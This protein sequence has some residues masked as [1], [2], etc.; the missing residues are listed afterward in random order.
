MRALP[1]YTPA[2]ARVY[3]SSKDAKGKNKRLSALRLRRR[4]TP[5][6][7]SVAACPRRRGRR[8]G[9]R[10]GRHGVSRGR[11]PSGAS[12]VPRCAWGGPGHSGSALQPRGDVLPAGPLRRGRARVPGARARSQVGPSR[13]LQ[14]R[15]DR[16]ARGAPASGDRIL[17]TGV[18]HDHGPELA[19]SRGDGPRAAGQHAAVARDERRD[20][21]G[22]RLRQQRD[23]VAGRRD[24]RGQPPGRPI[25]RGAGRGEP[26]S[27]R[28]SRAG[29][30][31]E[32]DSGRVQTSVGAY[33]DTAYIGRD[34][35]EQVASV[36]A[37]ASWRLDAGG[38][39]RGRY[40]FAHVAGGGGFEYLDGRQ[41]RLSADAGFT[42]AS[43]LLRVGYQVELNDRRDLQ[44]GSEFFSASPTRHSLFASVAL[45]NL[46][47][48]QADARGE[49]RVSRYRD[50][51]LIDGG[52]QGILE[53]TRRDQRYG[54]AL[55]ASRPVAAPWRVFIDYSYYRNESNL[56]PYD[57]SRHQL[58]AGI[59]ASLEK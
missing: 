40:R 58:M 54:F 17:R 22:G 41:Q 52:A 57:Y 23:A 37:Q 29:L 15:L 14:P 34:R 43:A 12:I 7:R 46:A 4:F 44:Q 28:G 48:W 53:V 30:S 25:R 47:G 59:E 18:P 10:A 51:N 3:S 56:D 8:T 45:R 20:L 1:E 32:R 24:G 13:P 16:A 27:G 11:L 36:D 9:C 49:Y 19:H 33:F 55:R 31:H 35:L 39:L 26:P 38:E 5:Q 50:P 21:L 6:Y 42:L 2:G